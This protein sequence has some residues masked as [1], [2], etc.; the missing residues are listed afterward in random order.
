M[1][2]RNQQPPDFDANALAKGLPSAIPEERLIIGSVLLNGERFSE[3]GAKLK[4]DDFALESHRR[5][6]TRMNDMA[7][8]GEK[9]DRIT[10]AGE[11]MKHQ[12]L[13]SVGGLSALVSMDDGLPRIANLGS[14]IAAVK[15]KSDARRIIF[16]CQHTMNQAL[17]GEESPDDLLRGAEERLLGIGESRQKEDGGLQSAGSFLRNFPGGLQNFV[18][19]AKRENGLKTGFAKFDEMTGGFRPGELIIFAARPGAGKSAIATNIAWHIATRFH[20]PVAIFSLEMSRESLLLRMLCAGAHVDSQ[21]LRAG[22]TNLDERNKIRRAANELADAPIYIDDSSNLGLMEMHAKVRQLERAQKIKF[23]L[24]IVDY[25][26]LM[27]SKERA[28]NRN[29]EVSRISRGLKML[30]KSDQL[31]VP[32]LALSQ[33][34]REA[35]KRSGGDI[36]PQLTDLRES[37]SLEQ[38]ADLVAFVFREELHRRDRT[39]LH[40]LAELIIGKQRAGPVGTCNLVWIA[41][42]QRFGD[43]CEDGTEAPDEE[44]LPYAD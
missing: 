1:S 36:R 11:L 33:L 38:D 3:I 19:P 16:A 37:G 40:G 15:D 44:R 7:N 42:E 29:Q 24:L 43:R 6:W 9:I 10:V 26:Q 14:Y 12:E 41:G 39:D 25:L 4:L 30:A 8:R 2:R 22:Y 13:E 35:G 34:S 18:E 5:I 23:G 27:A 21:R 17:V 28:E 32:V 31:N 20:Q